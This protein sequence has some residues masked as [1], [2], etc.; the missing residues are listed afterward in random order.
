MKAWGYKRRFE[1]KPDEVFPLELLEQYPVPPLR[2]GAMLVRMK[3]ATVNPVDWKVIGGAFRLVPTFMGGPPFDSKNGTV[4]CA[5]GAG[6]VVQSR[7]ERF[8]VGSEI[9]F[10]V[11]GAF[12][13]LAEYCVVGEGNA[14]P[15]PKGM[16]FADAAANVG[17]AS[18]TAVTAVS[19]LL[20]RLKDR[21]HPLSFVVLGGGGG[22]GSAGAQPFVVFCGLIR[23][24]PSAISRRWATT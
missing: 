3:A 22:V 10:D 8:P 11:G 9:S 1:G 20:D 2:A 24:Q 14:T 19:W 7:S 12:G 16:S 17:L 21:P 15:K 4:P 13:A 18:G 5:D 23:G 6:V